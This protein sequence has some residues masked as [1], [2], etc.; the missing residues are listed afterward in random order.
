MAENRQRPQIKDIPDIQ[1]GKGQPAKKLRENQ[2]L[3]GH[4]AYQ[5]DEDELVRPA[6]MFLRKDAGEAYGGKRAVSGRRER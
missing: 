5:G 3:C 2:V 1:K 4:F 6:R